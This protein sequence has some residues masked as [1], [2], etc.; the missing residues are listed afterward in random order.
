MK[1]TM[2]AAAI[3]LLTASAVNAMTYRGSFESEWRANGYADKPVTATV[4]ATSDGVNFQID[5]MVVQFTDTLPAS[6][7]TLTMGSTLDP[8]AVSIDMFTA[9]QLLSFVPSSDI[10]SITPL[11]FGWNLQ[12]NGIY[13]KGSTFQVVSTDTQLGIVGSPRSSDTLF[14]FSVADEITMSF[15]TTPTGVWS[16]SS[17]AIP[18]GT[19]GTRLLIPTS[20]FVLS[21]IPEPT[22][23]ALTM[24]G[25][26]GL[27]LRKR[28]R[29]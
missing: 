20:P 12:Y 23:L 26:A 11:V 13:R 21:A 4:K 14:D 27:G 24:L 18:G 10:A 7:S 25:M 17:L 15:S 16:L 1:T 8:I 19:V 6:G 29:A 28:R 2:F 5:S 22:T 9:S 3:I